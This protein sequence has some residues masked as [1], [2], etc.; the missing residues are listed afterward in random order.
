MSMQ[1]KYENGNNTKSINWVWQTYIANNLT[2]IFIQRTVIRLIN[3]IRILIIYSRVV[4]KRN[5]SRD[6]VK[7]H[8]PFGLFMN[9]N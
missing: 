7:L 6:Q 5:L 8:R 9:Y 3:Y 2:G 4:Y 1:I